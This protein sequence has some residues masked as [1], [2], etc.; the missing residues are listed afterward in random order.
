MRVTLGLAPEMTA[1]KWELAD[2]EERTT[3]MGH[4]LLRRLSLP[5][6]NL[7]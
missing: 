5:P 3:G 1:R 4:K 2:T 6:E 7:H